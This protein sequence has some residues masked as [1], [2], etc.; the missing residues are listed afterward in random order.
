MTEAEW[1]TATVPATMLEFL[2]NKTSERKLRLFACSC[3]RGVWHRLRAESLRTA[4]KV[5]EKFADGDAAASELETASGFAWR[6]KYQIEEAEI[7]FTNVA[8]AEAANAFFHAA[9]AAA[10]TAGSPFDDET[11]Y[12][13]RTIDVA[14]STSFVFSSDVVEAALSSGSG[15]AS[16][17]EERAASESA[18]KAEEIK[19]AHF[20]RDVVGNP[21]R[22]VTFDSSWL[23]STVSALAAGIYTES[24]FD[25]LPILADALQDAGCDNEDILTH[26]RSDGPH[27]KGC[28]ALD[29][30]LGKA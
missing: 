25:R 21:F 8:E 4:V 16:R 14:R 19:Q 29:L 6:T 28:W 26:F 15:Y 24:A 23:T 3:C 22:P 10:Q 2:E 18:R 17:D 9:E 7:D 5:S 13:F 20:L 1:S 30:V 11:P 12:I 27:V